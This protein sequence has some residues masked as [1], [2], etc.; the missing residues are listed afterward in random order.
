M[1]S[2][3]NSKTG[4]D[5]V[6][7]R[8]IEEAQQINLYNIKIFQTIRKLFSEQEFGFEICLGEITKKTTNQ[9]LSFLHATLL[10][11][12]KFASTKYYQISQ[13]VSALWP[14]QDFGYQGGKYITT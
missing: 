11:D 1:K 12:L 6:T 3:H 10:L 5:V 9:E 2:K 7:G 14:A 4:N 8:Y 13:T